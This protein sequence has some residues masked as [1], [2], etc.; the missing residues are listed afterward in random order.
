MRAVRCTCHDRWCIPCQADRAS[1]IQHAVQT[2]IGDQPHRLVTLTLRSSTRPLADQIDKLLKSFRKLRQRPFWRDRVL[3]G[4][5]FVE[6]TL[7]TQTARW[8][9]HLHVICHG[10][11]L[12]LT[13]LKRI[14]QSITGDSFIVDVRLIRDPQTVAK[15]VAKYASKPADAKLL[16]DVERMVEAVQA[17]KG[18]RLAYTF[19][20]WH[21]VSLLRT[22]E[23]SEWEIYDHASNLLEAAALGRPV[24]PRLLHWL[25]GL[26]GPA[27]PIELRLDPPLGSDSDPPDDS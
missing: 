27:A 1:K 12:P 17:L 24:D 25:R 19:G 22:G 8:H 14:W 9:P 6:L 20:D 26:D 7:N 15:Y 18:R 4:A 13:T 21:H 11:F 5:A 10:N 3:G 2:I 16:S 23:E